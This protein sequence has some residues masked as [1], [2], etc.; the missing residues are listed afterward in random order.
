MERPSIYVIQA[1][2]GLAAESNV[3]T[4]VDRSRSVTYGHE[5][6]SNL[7]ELMVGTDEEVEA[8]GMEVEHPAERAAIG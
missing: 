5:L 8:F 3:E 4:K 2:Y 1:F 7:E 6:G